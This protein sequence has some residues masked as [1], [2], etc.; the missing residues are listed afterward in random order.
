MGLKVKSVLVSR[1]IDPPI[2]RPLL[3]SMLLLQTLSITT[4]NTEYSIWVV[5]TG[6]MNFRTFFGLPILPTPNSFYLQNLQIL[7]KKPPR[8]ELKW[9]KL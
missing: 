1:V 6:K 4:G 7:A 9:A 2:K 8:Q 3:A 5:A